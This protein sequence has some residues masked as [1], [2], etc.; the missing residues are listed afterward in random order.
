MQCNA[1]HHFAT[2]DNWAAQQSRNKNTPSSNNLELSADHCSSATSTRVGIIVGFNINSKEVT[3][4][5]TI[6][7]MT[8]RIVLRFFLLAALWV[9]IVVWHILWL[10]S[11]F[12]LNVVGWWWWHVNWLFAAHSCEFQF[13]IIVVT[14]VWTCCIC[15]YLMFVVLLLGYCY[16]ICVIYHFA[17]FWYAISSYF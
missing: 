11:S 6:F 4:R 9:V 16:D 15:C 13:P 8:F 14:I 7:Y 12:N 10:K 5:I 2:A 1:I 3:N 17:P